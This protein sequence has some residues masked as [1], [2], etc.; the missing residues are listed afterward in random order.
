MGD[1]QL[2]LPGTARSCSFSV[3]PMETLGRGVP[4]ETGSARPR[5]VCW[6]WSASELGLRHPVA[7]VLLVVLHHEVPGTHQPGHGGERVQVGDAVLERP[8]GRIQRVGGGDGAHDLLLAGHEVPV[9]E[10]RLGRV[11]RV[12]PA[13]GGEVVA[14][15]GEDAG[16]GVGRVEVVDGRLLVGGQRRRLGEVVGDGVAEEQRRGCWPRRAPPTST[17]ATRPATE[18]RFHKRGEAAARAA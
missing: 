2:M 4:K 3:E 16:A 18:T 7:L 6:S 8:V 14:R 11:D 5:G 12:A 15:D 9:E 1:G 17:A 10:R 13:V